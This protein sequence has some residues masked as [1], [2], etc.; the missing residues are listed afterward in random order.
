MSVMV[1]FRSNMLGHMSATRAER[2]S[3][4]EQI[5]ANYRARHYNT[6]QA[7]VL[8]SQSTST[9]STNEKGTDTTAKSNQEDINALSRDAFLQ[10]LVL[11]MQNQDPLAPTDNTQMIAQLAQFSALEQMNNLNEQVA[12]LD[13]NLQLLAGNM[14]QANFINAQGLLGKYVEG[15]DYKGENIVTGTV[16]SVHLEGSIVML[17]I[18]EHIVPMSGVMSVASQAPATQNDKG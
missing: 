6:Q 15:I 1:G 10:L 17:S 18:G 9:K 13:S 3:A 14:D 5:T 8:S 4:M 12:L 7:E 2:I 11:Q 16:S